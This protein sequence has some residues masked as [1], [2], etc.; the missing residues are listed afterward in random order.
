VTANDQ[1]LVDLLHQYRSAEIRGAGVILK[2]ARLATSSY[3]RV[4]FSRHLKDE[5]VHA[6]LW[7][8]ALET[9]GADVIDVDDP[10]QARLG[11]IFGLPR[12]LVELLAL[13]V[14]SERRGLATYRAHLE[15]GGAPLAVE[16]TLRAVVK[17]E[18]WHVEWISAELHSGQF[19]DDEAQLV[20][21]RAEAADAD[22]V[23]SLATELGDSSHPFTRAAPLG[24]NTIAG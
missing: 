19:D 14:V 20:L 6:W 10:Y 17:D 7:T 21:R 23:K 24:E 15:M 13:T 8:R 5:G 2:L 22:A 4:N 11:Q 9:L 12:T 1:S 18:Q 3:Q 16:R